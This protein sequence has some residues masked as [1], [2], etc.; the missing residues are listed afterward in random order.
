MNQNMLDTNWDV[1]IIF[2]VKKLFSD[3]LEKLLVL[4]Y[5]LNDII[6]IE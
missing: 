4:Y 6:F 2:Y 5:M 1:I 3:F